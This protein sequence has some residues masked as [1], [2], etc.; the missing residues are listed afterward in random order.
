M[1]RKTKKLL[2]LA[3][4][5]GGSSTKAIGS[6]H[7]RIV[8]LVMSPEV[9]EINVNSLEQLRIDGDFTHHE[10]IILFLWL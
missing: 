3:I 2:K 1:A 8:P 5:F 4:D 10:K 6:C 7:D 9:I